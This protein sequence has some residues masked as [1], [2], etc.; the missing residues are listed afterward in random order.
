LADRLREFLGK[1][2]A[3]GKPK[4]RGSGVTA[5]KTLIATVQFAGKPQ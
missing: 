4:P 3:A 5:D 1:H 2:P